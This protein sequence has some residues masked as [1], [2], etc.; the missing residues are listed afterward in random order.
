MLYFSFAT[1]TRTTFS[2]SSKSKFATATS[3]KKTAIIS[4][5]IPL[6]TKNITKDIKAKANS[7]NVG[8]YL[9]KGFLYDFLER[10]NVITNVIMKTKYTANKKIS[11]TT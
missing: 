4:S 1:I 10:R 2:A 11:Q 6:F 3:P 9:I 5:P 8:M 7:I